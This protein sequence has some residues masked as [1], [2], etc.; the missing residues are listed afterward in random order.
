MS[1]RVGSRVPLGQSDGSRV[2]T[3]P[4]GFISAQRLVSW[5]SPSTWPSSCTAVS[6]RRAPLRQLRTTV[7]S[8]ATNG[9]GIAGARAARDALAAIAAHAA[10]ARVAED[11]ARACRR[12]AREAHADA[13]RFQERIASRTAE[14]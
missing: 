6:L 7:T 9:D 2:F 11:H 8:M 13:A 4:V 12:R 1:S 5:P 3:S 14:S 10:A